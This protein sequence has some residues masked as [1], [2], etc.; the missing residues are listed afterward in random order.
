VRAGET[1]RVGQISILFMSICRSTDPIKP[2]PDEKRLYV[3]SIQFE[4]GIPEAVPF[5]KG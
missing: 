1:T 3:A 5:E 2:K 4:T